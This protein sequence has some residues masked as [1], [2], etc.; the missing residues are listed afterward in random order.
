MTTPIAI[1]ALLGVFGGPS[2]DA[3][4]LTPPADM[5]AA[6]RSECGSCHVPYPPN[7]LSSG[8]LFSGGGWR[9]IIGDLRSHFGEN[10]ALEESVRRQ[11]EQYLLDHA[12]DERR[13]TSRTDPPRLTTTLWFRRNHGAVKA[14]FADAR[15]GSPANCPACHSRA[16]EGSYARSEVVL[17]DSPRRQG[18]K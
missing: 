7:L 11:I 1:A 17:P 13:F 6:Y 15:V 10:A 4:F 8:G 5:P 12:G 9:A 2:A 14:H 18:A 16:E 3:D